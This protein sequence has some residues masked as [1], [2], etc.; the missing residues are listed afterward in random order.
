MYSSSVTEPIAR[1]PHNR[2]GFTGAFPI[3]DGDGGAGFGE[4]HGNRSPDA[5]RRARH[6]RNAAIQIRLDGHDRSPCWSRRRLSI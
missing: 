4:R 1:P 3:V 5:A 6:Q 2:I